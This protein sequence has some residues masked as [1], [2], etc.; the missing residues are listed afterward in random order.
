M[1]SGRRFDGTGESFSQTSESHAASRMKIIEAA[2]WE[3][4][5]RACQ[6]CGVEI[7]DCADHLPALT[8]ACLCVASISSS[9]PMTLPAR[10]PRRS[11]G[12]GGHTPKVCR[13]M[14]PVVAPAALVSLAHP[15]RAEAVRHLTTWGTPTSRCCPVRLHLDCYRLPLWTAEGAARSRN[16]NQSGV[17]HRNHLRLFS[18]SPAVGGAMDRSPN[19]IGIHR[20]CGDGGPDVQWVKTPVCTGNEVQPLL[21][22]NTDMRDNCRTRIG[23]GQT[24]W[25]GSY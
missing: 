25:T 2:S 12:T 9:T 22:E 15:T 7:V 23:N 13:L 24:G 20:Q 5:S 19:A 21:T 3:S 4:G 16:P 8:P 1:F 14:L 6:R 10:T 18:S 11:S 17:D